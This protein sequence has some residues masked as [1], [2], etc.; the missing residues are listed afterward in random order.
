MSAVAKQYGVS[1]LLTGLVRMWRGFVP[2]LL[3]VLVNA[4]LQASVLGLGWWW[5]AIGISAAVLLIS[6]AMVTHLAVRS[7][8][9]RSGV[10]DLP[11]T[12]LL[13][14]SVWVIGWTVV[15]NL[16]LMVSFWPGVG[17]LALTPFLPVAAAAGARN[18]VAA[19][20]SAI[21]A[22]P[23]RWLFTV[24]ITLAVIGVLWLLSALNAFFVQGWVAAFSAWVVIGF[25]AA[26]LLTAWAALFASAL[27]E[28]S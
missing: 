26:W 17:I 2:L 9:Q 13:R 8:T 4:V 15:V 21:R 20:F 25:V 16:G 28:R 22:R 11:Q 19:N 10:S 24:F 12:D 18:P 23:W 1:V 5:L 27:G 6:F 3:V 14:F 7:V